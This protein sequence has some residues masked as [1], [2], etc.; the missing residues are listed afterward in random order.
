MDD[1]EPKKRKKGS[2]KQKEKCDRYGGFSQK[3]VRLKVLQ[4]CKKAS[5][6]EYDVKNNRNSKKI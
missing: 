4:S 3:H 6:D 5:T 2:E 1:F